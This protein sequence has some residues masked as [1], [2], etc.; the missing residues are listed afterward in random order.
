MIDFRPIILVTGILLTTLGSAMLIPAAIDAGAGNPDWQVFALA[1][2][3]TLFTGGSMTLMTWGHASDLTLKEA[4]LLVT[5]IW[6][7]LPGFGALPFAF[8]ELSLSYTDAFFEAMS[9]LTTTGATVVV[10]L[11]TAPPGFLLWRALLQWLGGL[12]VIVMAISVLPALQVGGMQIFRS[13]AFDTMGKIL[14]RAGEIAQSIS[15]IYLA[16]TIACGI[17]YLSLGMQPFD[18]VVHAMTTI[19]TGGFANT[20]A[21]FSQM[22]AA[23]EYAAVVFM[24]I[25]ALPF[26]RYV[27]MLQGSAKPLIH[28]PQVRAFFLVLFTIVFAVSLWK[29][30]AVGVSEEQSFRKSLFNTT[31]ILTGTG[32]ASADYMQWGAFPVVILFFAGLIGGCAGSTACSIKVFRFQLLIASIAVQIKRIH[33][34][35][36]VFTPRYAG[37]AVSQDVLSSVMAFFV[38]F[39]V[40]VGLLAVALGFTGLDFVTS[41]S[42]AATALAN[43]GPGL[44]DTI[45][46]AGNFASLNDTAKWMLAFAMLIGRLELMAVYAIFTIGF[47]R[48]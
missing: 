45:G 25:A 36:G 13:E 10:G 23:I 34:P 16:M 33:S 17:T 26:V 12:G 18:A 3:L 32:Y 28:D 14:P 42:E 11:D 30:F 46:P 1:A 35:H 44:G 41:L 9:G 6:V 5:F 47:W 8:S 4:F 21:S 2:T 31:S 24:L 40:S 27:Q 15:V 29:F 43:I 20:D 7:F 48:A 39:T 22:S 38:M 19:A 37:R